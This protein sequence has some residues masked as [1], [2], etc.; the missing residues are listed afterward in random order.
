[1]DVHSVQMALCFANGGAS[2]DLG[3]KIFGCKERG[4]NRPSE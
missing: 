3:L 1:V 4:P 2:R